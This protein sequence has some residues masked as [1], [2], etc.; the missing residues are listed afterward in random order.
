MSGKILLFSEKNH[1]LSGKILLFSEKMM[2][3]PENFL[4]VCEDNDMYGKFFELT[5]PPPNFVMLPTPLLGLFR[6]PNLIQMN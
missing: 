2:I 6:T 5:S 1:G 3:C 4:F